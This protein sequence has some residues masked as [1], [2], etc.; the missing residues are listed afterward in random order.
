MPQGFLV[1]FPV[2][3]D[4]SQD[5][6]SAEIGAVADKNEKKMHAD[7]MVENSPDTFV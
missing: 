7:C 3:L 2:L 5:P 1:V 6:S 4:H